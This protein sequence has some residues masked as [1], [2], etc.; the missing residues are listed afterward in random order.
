LRRVNIYAVTLP[1]SSDIKEAGR[2]SEM[3]AKDGAA[4]V[5]TLIAGYMSA[6]SGDVVS[7]PLPRKNAE[8]MYF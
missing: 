1:D 4:V 3:S 5:E 8:W 6:A 2:E 7:L